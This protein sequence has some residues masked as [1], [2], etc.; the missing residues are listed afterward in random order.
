MG[1]EPG[2]CP[3]LQAP[4]V[5]AAGRSRAWRREAVREPGWAG[6]RRGGGPALPG[7]VLTPDSVPAPR[8]RRV[9]EALSPH[10][11]VSRAQGRRRASCEAG[12]WPLP[13]THLETGLS[14]FSACA[15]MGFRPRARV[16]VSSVPR[17]PGPRLFSSF[18][19]GPACSP[20]NIEFKAVQGDMPV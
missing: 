16:P 1:V 18:S 9:S 10:W 4:A 14:R 3:R 12:T 20:L 8:L 13:C 7:P 19:L 2:T 17:E 5:P 15:E 11:T 6:L